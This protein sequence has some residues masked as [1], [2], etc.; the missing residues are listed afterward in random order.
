MVDVSGIRFAHSETIGTALATAGEEKMNTEANGKRIRIVYLMTSCRKSGPTQVVLNI[1]KNLDFSKFE[2]ILVTLYDEESDSQMGDILPY[3]SAHYLV[4]T[5]KKDIVL[6]QDGALRKKLEELNPDVI[7]ST[8]VFPDFAV[9]RIAPQKQMITLHNY[10]YEDYLAKFGKVRGTILARLQLSAIKKAAL[11][12]ACSE[13]LS[14]IYKDK[15]NLKVGFIRNGVDVSIFARAT[16]EE[17]LKYRKVLSIPEGAFVFIYTG[18]LIE[19]KNVPFL[20]EHY[21]KAINNNSRVYLVL[22]GDGTERKTLQESYASDRID[23]RGA[24]NNVNEYLRASDFYV[25]TSK[26]E[27]LP[28]GVLEAMATGIPVVLSD[29]R[30]HLEILEV[31]ADGGFA[32]HQ[33]DGSDFEKQLLKALECDYSNASNAA[34][35][36]AHSSFDAK[37]MSKQ[38]QDCYI[39]IKSFSIRR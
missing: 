37:R 33:A 26:S 7:H 20:L 3:V 29:I 22:L 11:V 21:V 13:S 17:K 2:P 8:G 24:V 5:G 28:N 18:Q 4:K 9:S 35:E 39:N 1:I 36:I 10:V 19:R 30:Q 12:V 38:Y 23:F 15:L 34:Y 31:N 25:S 32:Y 6:G 27:G 16:A 14:N